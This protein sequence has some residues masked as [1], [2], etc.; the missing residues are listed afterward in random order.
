MSSF[1][2]RIESSPCRVPT[3]VF[4]TDDFPTMD[5]EGLSWRIVHRWWGAH[6][7]GTVRAL[8]WAGPRSPELLAETVVLRSPCHVEMGTRLPQ[9][10]YGFVAVDT[11]TK[12]CELIPTINKQPDEIV[13]ALKKSLDWEE[14]RPPESKHGIKR[15]DSKDD[16]SGRVGADLFACKFALGGCGHLDFRCSVGTVCSCLGAT[17]GVEITRGCT[18]VCLYVC[19]HEQSCPYMWMRACMCFARKRLCKHPRVQLRVC[20]VTCACVR[21]RS[22]LRTAIAT[23]RAR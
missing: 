2:R 15:S 9:Y 22:G 11:F 20:V 23:P 21:G 4:S 16:L 7:S 5:F 6:T 3:A 12:V 10:C 1:K 14:L 17:G 13:R 19:A 8:L 18:C